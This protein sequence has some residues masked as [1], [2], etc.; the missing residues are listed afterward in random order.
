MK[1][2]KE[3]KKIGRQVSYLLRHKEHF[4]DKHGYALVSKVL[5]STNL[6]K[7]ELN[8]IVENNDKKR[9]LYNDDETLIRA[10]QGHSKEVDLGLKAIPAEKVPFTLYHGTTYDNEMSIREKG[11][12]KMNRQYVHLSDNKKTAENVGKRYSKDKKPLILEIHAKLMEFE[13]HKIYISENGVY[14]TDNVAPLYIKF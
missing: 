7:E 13:G 14:L 1:I 3:L 10:N 4:T 8:W 12:L 9:F 6:T 2:E 5:N 11:L